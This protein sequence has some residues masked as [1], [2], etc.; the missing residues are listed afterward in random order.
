[1]LS[2][3]GRVRKGARLVAWPVEVCRRV[4][5][6]CTFSMALAHCSPAA[7][8]GDQLGLGTTLLLGK[9]SQPVMGCC[10]D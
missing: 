8:E 6:L 4:L 2:I 9:A 3:S 7:M 10:L 5:W 1:M